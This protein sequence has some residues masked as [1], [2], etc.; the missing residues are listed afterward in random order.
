MAPQ[1]R[2]PDWPGRAAP[3]WRTAGRSWDDGAAGAVTGDPGEGRRRP[4]AWE[5]VPLS[6]PELEPTRA[7]SEVPVRTPMTG[8][9]QD[10]DP[11]RSTEGD[12][13]CTRAWEDSL[14]STPPE[15]PGGDGDPQRDDD[16]PW[17]HLP[18]TRVM[19]P[20]LYD[21][22]HEMAEDVDDAASA[23]RLLSN[24][25]ARESTPALPGCSSGTCRLLGRSVPGG[26]PERR[27]LPSA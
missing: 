16:D 11:A 22:W 13:W 8:S 7:P 4:R 1:R 27:R 19:S 14:S 25:L 17:Q 21:M 2:P 20:S 6:G 3:Q 15:D 10:V 26:G 23:S 5:S 18:C 12:V 9:W 24:V